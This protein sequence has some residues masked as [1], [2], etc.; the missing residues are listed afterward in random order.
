M[1]SIKFYVDQDGT[2]PGKQFLDQVALRNTDIKRK[3]LKHLLP[4]LDKKG[5]ELAEPHAKPLED[6]IIELRAMDSDHWYRWFYFFNQVR[7]AVML[8]GIIK[9]ELKTPESALEY[10]KSLKNDYQERV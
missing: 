5:I 7:N 3:Y 8:N 2:K 10:A 1:E 9:Q 6:G 4:L